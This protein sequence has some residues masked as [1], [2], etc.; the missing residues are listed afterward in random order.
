MSAWAKSS[1]T[2]RR[3]QS[4]PNGSN[5][6]HRS[7]RRAAPYPPREER[8][9]EHKDALKRYEELEKQHKYSA[10]MQFE[11]YQRPSNAKP[12]GYKPT[13]RRKALYQRFYRQVQDEKEP[14]D[15]VVLSITNQCTDYPKSL[16]EC[17][18]G[19]GLSV[20]ML[21]LQAE[22]GLTRALQDIRADG[23]PLC[24]LVEHTNVALSSC[25]V[26]IFSESLKIHRNMPKDQAMDFV[27]GEYNRGLVKERPLKDPADMAARAS[28]MLNDVLEREKVERHAVPSDTRHLLLLLAE[29]VHLYPE[30]LGTVSQ[31]LRSRQDHMQVPLYPSLGQRGPCLVPPGSTP[32]CRPVLCCPRQAPI[33]KPSLLPC[34]PCIGPR[35][36]RTD[37]RTAHPMELILALP[38]L[39]AHRLYTAPTM[40]LRP[41]GPHT[42]MVHST[43]QGLV[44]GLT[45]SEG[46]L[47]C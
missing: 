28:Q 9:E 20:E 39:G 16:G 30:E 34:C 38:L 42:I 46:A 33:P 35:G 6:A 23:S 21:Y 37:P 47:P 29:G 43:T 4:T 32:S 18:Q 44:A 26:I 36:P 1:G 13:D 31:Y 8:P 14:A 3:A 41:A 11:G 2:G 17:L 15:C 45:V 12:E 22:S 7:F 27:A 10:N 40:A 25:T 24:I 5:P 19:R